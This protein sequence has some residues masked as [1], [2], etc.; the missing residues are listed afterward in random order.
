MTLS[1]DEGYVLRDLLGAGKRVTISLKLDDRGPREP[2]ERERLGHAAGRDG[3]TGLRDGALRLIL[4]GRDGQ[5][6]GH[7][8]ADGHRAPLRRSSPR[9]AAAD[10]GLLS[11]AGSSPRVGRPY[12]IRDNYDW[13]KVAFIVNC[14]H[15]SQTLLYVFGGD[16]MTSN[17]ISARRWYA[18]G[19]DAFKT[20]VRNSLHEFNVSVYT[21]PET[22]AGGS[23]GR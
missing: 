5:R 12:Q 3:R 10:A 23:L 11:D 22:N 8:D 6:L 17:A 14:E 2:E 9:A 7:G 18:N 15:P 19:S 20:L 1:Q 16:L 4:P 13:S 21:V